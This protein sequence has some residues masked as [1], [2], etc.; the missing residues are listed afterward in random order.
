MYGRIFPKLIICFLSA[1]FCFFAIV[2]EAKAEQKSESDKGESSKIIIR[3]IPLECEILFLDRDINKVE[4]QLTITEIPAGIHPIVFKLDDETLKAELDIQAGVAYA[5]KAHF[6]QRRVLVTPGIFIGNDGAP[7]VIIPAGEFQMG[8]SYGD[9][10]EQPEHTLYLDE[11][12]MDIYEVTNALYKK[13]IDA[14]GHKS[15]RY[16]SN[17]EYNAPD[18]PVVGVTWEDAK[19]YCKWAGKRLPTESEWEKAA[20][21]GLVGK[22]Y[23]W[24]NDIDDPAIG[25]RNDQNVFSS[26][27]MP[28]SGA[29]IVGDFAPN[30]YGLYDMAGNAWEWCVDWYG[31]DYYAKSPGRNPTGPGS[32]ENRVTRGGSWPGHIS[33]PLSVSYRYSYNPEQTSDLIGFR[34]VK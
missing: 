9:F 29:I 4:D 27:G 12:Y 23:P 1:T 19:A 34:C 17:S 5:V 2:T 24:G 30:N 13:F 15:P 32:G 28:S 10:D 7:M 22:N 8:N 21:G 31:E 18:Q 6:K 3:S 26:A 25:I 14:T 16:W 20:R 33:S 11:F